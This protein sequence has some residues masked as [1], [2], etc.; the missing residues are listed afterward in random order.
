MGLINNAGRYEVPDMSSPDKFGDQADLIL[1]TNYW[2]LKNVMSTMREILIPGAR[3]V[4]TSSHLGHLSLINGEAKKSLHLREQLADPNIE[5]NKLD[6]LMEDFQSFARSGIG[7][8]RVGQT[9][10]TL[11]Q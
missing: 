2:G 9:V 6:K 4:N 1:G 10:P 7:K 11:C 5:E 3:I 8:R